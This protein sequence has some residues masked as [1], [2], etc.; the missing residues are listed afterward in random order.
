MRKK[1]IGFFCVIIFI[2]FISLL[3]REAICFI[4]YTTDATDSTI[5]NVNIELDGKLVFT[6]CIY[7]DFMHDIKKRVN[8]DLG[9]GYHSMKVT[10]VNE[11]RKQTVNF[12]YFWQKFIV[13]NFLPYSER[14]NGSDFFWIAL[15]NRTPL[16]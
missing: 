16:M 3:K 2:L 6:D 12:F 11:K 8:L 13:I 4:G 9:V 10:I 1:Y 5:L 7:S 14:K 15:H